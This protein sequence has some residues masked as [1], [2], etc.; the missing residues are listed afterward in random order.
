MQIIDVCSQ[1]LQFERRGIPFAHRLHDDIKRAMS[2]GF[3]EEEIGQA[4]LFETPKNAFKALKRLNK[5]PDIV[6]AP[7]KEKTIWIGFV[8]TRIDVCEE[9]RELWN[10]FLSKHFDVYYQDRMFSSELDKI[11]VYYLRHNKVEFNRDFFYRVGK[12]WIDY[13]CQQ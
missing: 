8:K 5:H 9:A 2:S 11:R 12:D 6:R 3:T 10:R 13:R 4:I 7:R 1:L